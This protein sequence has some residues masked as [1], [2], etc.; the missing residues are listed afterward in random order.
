MPLRRYEPFHDPTA[1]A[2]PEVNPYIERLRLAH[3]TGT[4]PVLF[5]PQ[6]A[7]QAGQWRVHLQS[8]DPSL[9]NSAPL[10]V[11]IGSYKGA[12]LRRMAE[13][14]A[15]YGFVGLDITFKRIVVAAQLMVDS[16]LRNTCCALANAKSFEQLFAPEEVDGI[17][18]FFPDPWPKLRHAKNRLLD[19]NFC[20]AALKCLRPGGFIWLKTDQRPYFDQA[21]A[22]LL[23]AGFQP[24]QVPV[25][26][27]AEAYSSSFEERFTA[28]KIGHFSGVWT[29][30][31]SQAQ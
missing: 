3:E 20:A 23:S 27:P 30:C 16:N 31:A 29:K 12:T 24:W 2:R 6:L 18:I 14:H 4:L 17:V 8:Q 15:D 26:I 13:T 1:R 28:K 21:E 5:G 10:I 11:E 25:G 19:E 7:D 9:S 22:A